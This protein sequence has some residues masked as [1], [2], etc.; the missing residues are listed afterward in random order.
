M[1]LRGV[2]ACDN[3]ALPENQKWPD[4]AE[5]RGAAPQMPWLPAC[6][7][8]AS[9][10]GA[11]RP[12]HRQP[13]QLPMPYYASPEECQAAQVSLR[14]SLHAYTCLHG[15]LRSSHCHSIYHTMLC[16]GVPVCRSSVCLF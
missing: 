3:D 5:N 7:R 15:L 10:A 8:L 13:P 2:G 6:P 4:R 14:L 16:R 1:A 12:L 9:L 11:Q